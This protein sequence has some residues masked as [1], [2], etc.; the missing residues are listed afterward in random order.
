MK[1]S[2]YI[3][4]AVLIWFSAC[5]RKPASTALINQKASL[6]ATFS[7]S[8]LNQKVLT[9]F[10][11]YRDSS[12]SIL[13]GDTSAEAALRSGQPATS[14]DYKFTLVTWHQQDDPHWFG[15]RIP[16]NLVSVEQLSKQAGSGGITYQRYKGNKLTGVTDTTGNA[17]R[18]A[19]IL[20]KK[21]SILP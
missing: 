11:N 16:G 9:S 8:K 7:V 10:I 6:P 12:M 21:L 13:Y 19:F 17:S 18:I 1:A 15:A 20:S 5:N 4:L 3:A 14:A 2:K